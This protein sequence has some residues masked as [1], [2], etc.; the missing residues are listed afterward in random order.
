MC[1]EPEQQ[2]LSIQEQLNQQQQ[3]LTQIYQ[4][5]EK[6][7][8]YI[9]WT[10]VANLALLIIPLIIVL[11]MLPRIMGI[12]SGSMESLLS[13]GATMDFQDNP[14]LQESLERLQ[15]LL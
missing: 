2:E 14:S 11:V 5:V 9:F 6:T 7:R 15:R 13:T 4:S 1:M 3:A 12:F 10:G 8:K